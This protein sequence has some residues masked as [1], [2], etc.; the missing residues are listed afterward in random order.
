MNPLSNDS[1]AI[2]N[3]FQFV[4]SVEENLGFFNTMTTRKSYTIVG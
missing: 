3:K 2:T 4:E 1:Y